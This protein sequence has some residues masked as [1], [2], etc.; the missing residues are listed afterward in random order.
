L[1]TFSLFL[2][3]LLVKLSTYLLSLARGSR[4]E[5][6]CQVIETATTSRD[7]VATPVPS[8]ISLD[9]LRFEGRMG[10]EEE[11]GELASVGAG[12][13]DASGSAKIHFR[14]LVG[15]NKEHV[16]YFTVQGTYFDV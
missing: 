10:R 13:A 12:G 9:D 4:I 7:E 8:S 2:A 14:W 15:D 6:G 3:R 1:C 5:R 11:L 16:L